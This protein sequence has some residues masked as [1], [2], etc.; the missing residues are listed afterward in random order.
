MER[1]GS[2]ES[3][4]DISIHC[5]ISTSP[6]VYERENLYENYRSPQPSL[7]SFQFTFPIPIDFRAIGKSVG[8]FAT[9]PHHSPVL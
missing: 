7:M 4:P 8:I 2:I 3:G 5:S 1:G 9:I 6:S